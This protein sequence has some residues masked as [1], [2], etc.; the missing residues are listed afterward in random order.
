L[1]GRGQKLLSIGIFLA[2]SYLD[3]GKQ[4]NMGYLRARIKARLTA[5]DL[6]FSMIQGT[7]ERR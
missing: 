7:A 2:F 3:Q 5:V 1:Q 6:T 4:Q